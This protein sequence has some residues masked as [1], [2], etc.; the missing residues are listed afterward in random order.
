MAKQDNNMLHLVDDVRQTLRFRK[1]VFC[2]SVLF[3]GSILLLLLF[4]KISNSFLLRDDQQFALFCFIALPSAILLF[5]YFRDYRTKK[6]SRQGIAL[7]VEEATPELMDSYVCA[8]EIAE[9]GGATGRIEEALTTSVSNRFKSG[10]IQKIVTPTYLSSEILGLVMVVALFSAFAL[11]ENPLLKSVGNF[12]EYQ[13]TGVHQGFE[14]TPGNV[15]LAKGS[16]L[17]VSVK[18]ESGEQKATLEYMESGEWKSLEMNPDGDKTMSA[19]VYSLEENTKYRVIT[20]RFKS[21]TYDVLVFLKPDFEKVEFA[22]TPPSYTKKK[23]FVL[24]DFKNFAIPQ[25]SKVSLVLSA[26]KGVSFSLLENNETIP[27]SSDYK[28]N[29]SYE[30]SVSKSANYQLKI[31]DADGNE[32]LSKPFKVSVVRDMPPHIEVAKPAKDLQKTKF[33]IVTLEVS[34]L[35]DYGLTAVNLHIE[36]SF[37]SSE[38]NEIYKPQGGDLS[39]EENLFYDLNLKELGLTEGDVLTYYLEARDNAEPK[40]QVSRTKIYFLEIRP[41][42]NDVED[43]QEEQEGGDEQELSV[44][45][46]IA[47]QK[48]LIRSLID[49]KSVSPKISKDEF[50]VD[51]ASLQEL[52][53]QTATL[54]LAVQKRMDE[55]K[56]EAEKMGASLGVIGDLFASSIEELKKAEDVTAKSQLLGALRANNKSLSDLIKIAI[57]L[58]KNSQKSQS[59]QQQQQKEDQEQ[60]QQQE[61]QEQERLA[62]MLKKL[63]DLEDQQQEINDQFK[64]TKEDDLQ[65]QQAL[66]EKMQEQQ[67]RLEEMSES[68]EEQQQQQASENLQQAAQQIQQGQQQM[69]QGDQQGA[70]QQSQ[71]AQQRIENAKNDI[72]RAMRDQARKKLKQLADVLDKTVEEQQDINEK[73]QAV[74]NP[75]GEEGKKQMAELKKRQDKVQETMQKLMD[76]LGAAANELDEKYPEVAEAL[77]ESREFAS[78]Q[79]IDRRLKRSSNALHYR[80]QASAERE[81]SKAEESMTLLG[82]KVRDAVGRLPQA[83]LEELMQ[84][85]QEVEV[86]RRQVGS[87]S[88]GTSRQAVD[89]RTEQIQKMMEE[90][91]Q[92]LQ[93]TDM[94]Y[95]IPQNLESAKESDSELKSAV[96]GQMNALNQAAFILDSMISK[97]DLEKRL[98]LNKQTGNA[99]D[100]YKRSVREY[101]KS[102]SDG[103]K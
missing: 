77:R 8:L 30:M 73:T 27:I 45:D 28:I 17:E 6:I 102:L 59:K 54:R 83:T 53:S 24:K 46:L 98:T 103:Q 10:E 37:G 76:Q 71:Q 43:K 69:Q 35:D 22:I 78:N 64:E 99:P 57:E 21:K 23:P 5:K 3:S 62:D 7:K 81:Q 87:T 52:S 101:L 12:L 32:E 63:E 94:E 80:R 96:Q 25:D 15:N 40:S 20:D 2:L 50:K 66:Q 74:E 72:K 26:N 9:K 82:Y 39:K 16:D 19:V 36:Y 44:D 33:D 55:L 97:A 29:H 14:V 67:E 56:K 58:E 85:R 38:E 100:K 13:R 4:S 42:K 61:E 79:G 93:N 48:D 47:T 60:Q 88:A 11:F 75:T 91:G 68:L 41:D 31:A 95:E 18:I 34:A 70:Q 89:Q 90:M 84:M 1:L 49:T 51:A 86:A 92:T 65:E